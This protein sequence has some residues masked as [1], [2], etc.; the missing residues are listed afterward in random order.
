MQALLRNVGTAG[1]NHENEY[2]SGMGQG[3]AR[4]RKYEV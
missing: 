1:E 4:H 2:V 3:E